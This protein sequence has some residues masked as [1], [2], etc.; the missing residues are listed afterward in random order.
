LVEIPT[1][2]QFPLGVYVLRASRF[3][4]FYMTL[5]DPSRK[6]IVYPFLLRGVRARW[7]QAFGTS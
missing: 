1:V 2:Y 7:N 6:L 4:P 5:I 3:T